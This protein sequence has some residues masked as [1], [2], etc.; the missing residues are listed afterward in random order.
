MITATAQKTI[1]SITHIGIPRSASDPKNT[2]VDPDLSITTG[3]LTTKAMKNAIT[4]GAQRNRSVDER[5]RRKPRPIPRKLPSSTK[6]EKYE[7]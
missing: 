3:N 6:F 2:S 5:A 7:R 4:T 1:G